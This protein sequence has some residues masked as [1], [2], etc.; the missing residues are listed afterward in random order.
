MFRVKTS[1]YD[2]P[3]INPRVLEEDPTIGQQLAQ[4]SKYFHMKGTC[5]H[6]GLGPP[7]TKCLDLFADSTLPK[8]ILKNLEG[9]TLLRG[10]NP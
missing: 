6:C 7:W 1:D 8:I 4:G 9:T 2:S 3:R 10:L 5:S